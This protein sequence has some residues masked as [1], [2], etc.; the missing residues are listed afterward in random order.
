VRFTPRWIVGNI[1]WFPTGAPWAMWRVAPETITY[2]P[3]DRQAEILDTARAALL[4][5]PGE[6]MILSVQ[7]EEDPVDVHDRMI[8]GVDT[9]AHPAWEENA[10]EVFAHLSDNP[11][12]TRVFYIAVELA[13]AS[14]GGRAFTASPI[15]EPS[16]EERDYAQADA[17]S[18]YLALGASLDLAPVTQAELEWVY[19]RAFRRGAAEP[20]MRVAEPEPEGEL[21][22]LEAQ[23]AAEQGSSLEEMDRAILKEGGDSYD[24]E[25]RREGWKRFLPRRPRRYLKLTTVE[26]VSFQSFLV[27]HRTPWFFTPA[28]LLRCDLQRFPVDWCIRIRSVENARALEAVKRKLEHLTQQG[29]EREAE[30]RATGEMPGDLA[31]AI[32]A[33]QEF[34]DHLAA[35]NDPEHRACVIFCVYG[36]TAQDAEERAADLRRAYAPIDWR[37]QRP[38]GGQ[39]P[40]F[41]ASLPGTLRRQAAMLMADYR[42]HFFPEDLSKLGLFLG[43]DLGDRSGTLFGYSATARHTR[44]VLINP[45]EAQRIGRSGSALFVGAPGEGKALALDTPIPTP[46]GWTTMG[47]IQVGDEVLDE[48]GRPTR[49]TATSQVQPNRPCY[50]VVFDDGSVIVADEG[51]LWNTELAAY[52]SSVSRGE[53]RARTGRPR[54]YVRVETVARATEASALRDAGVPFREIAEQLGY[55][56]GAAVRAAIARLGASR[57]APPKPS[58]VTTGEIKATLRR[59]DGGTNHAVRL[60][61][62]LD[63]PEIPLPIDPYVLGAWLGDGTSKDT[64][65]TT[66]DADVQ[67]IDEIRAAGYRVRPLE[68]AASR[69]GFYRIDPVQRGAERSHCSGGHLR[70]EESTYTWTN[71]NGGRGVTLCRVCQREGQQRRNGV[72][73]VPAPTKM[74]VPSF[75]D[76]LTSLGLLGNKHIPPQYL[77]ASFAQRLALLQ[78]LMDTDGH[79][80]VLGQCEFVSVHYGLAENVRE[81]IWSLGVRASLIKGTARL[82]GVDCGPKY[83]IHFSTTLPAFRL[84]R[85]VDRLPTKLR[86]TSQYRYIVDVRPVASVPVKCIVVDS[87]THLFLA[88][89]SMIPTHNSITGKLLATSVIDQAGMVTAIDVTNQQEWARWLAVQ[90]LP[91][92]RKALVDLTESPTL[93]I[94]PLRV[95]AHDPGAGRRYA[96]GFATM[97]AGC[98]P[99]GDEG[100]SIKEA[101]EQSADSPEPSMPLALEILEDMARREVE[102]A[103]LALRHLNTFARRP[104]SGE[105]LG[106]LVFDRDRKVLDLRNIDALVFGAAG[107][108]LP[109]RE[110]MLSPDLSRN[111]LPEQHFSVAILYA[112]AA[113]QQAFTLLDPQ[114]FAV[115]I[116]D[117]A[118]TYT[119]TIPG[120][121]LI[122]GGVRK[123]RKENAAV[124]ILTQHPGDVP[125][126]LAAQFEYRFLFGQARNAGNEAAV[127]LG[128]EP[129][130]DL[131]ILLEEK[132]R[133]RDLDLSAPPAPALCLLRDTL[134]RVGL[135]WVRPP[136]GKH[137]IAYETNPARMRQLEEVPA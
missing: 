125:P 4:E 75:R 52:R 85:K 17:R 99:R 44:L 70:T 96:L 132:M 35:T 137:A 33:T 95:F 10:L 67:V 115:A 87:P 91:E 15:S 133:R 98:D 34:R 131:R 53:A 23:E 24:L 31:R 104:K 30:I 61:Q 89:R 3:D 26:T 68:K 29:S 119:A 45:A 102:G 9:Q 12:F 78:G 42:Q 124:W 101:I 113:V 136:Q 106:A 50:E 108:S 120:R 1:A 8:G 56:N 69:V 19:E 54:R 84:Q 134:G 121:S 46:D 48:H 57:V 107:L 116:L 111:L 22:A 59:A 43:L 130:D 77:R 126:E 129:T 2:L 49:V 38:T 32:I 14:K 7:P 60:C 6:A 114:R 65:I 66:A 103:A 5:L 128:L 62:P 92:E 11:A 110:Q 81:L 93:S 40:L 74:S 94:D 36:P 88:G 63:L 123:G 37:L 72:Q 25:L 71:P 80:T 135:V 86:S 122:E 64:T 117:E 112:V 109:T 16:A 18:F 51:H 127:L 21:Q 97:I 41:T 20:P 82:N 39:L 27:L 76:H 100:T 28:E 58:T 73:F 105:W 118:H 47:E 79:V 55:R 13:G 83:A 90:D